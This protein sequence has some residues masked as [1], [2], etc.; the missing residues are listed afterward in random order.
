[1]YKIEFL[2]SRKGIKYY[3][4][5]VQFLRWWERHVAHYGAHYHLKGYAQLKDCSWS[6]IRNHLPP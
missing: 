4:T 1:M 6:L 5:R 3:E 2:K